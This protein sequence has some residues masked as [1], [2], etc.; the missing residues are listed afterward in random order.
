MH[1]NCRCGH[2]VVA[3]ILMVLAWVAAIGFWLA[4]WKHGK[5]VSIS[6]EHYLKEVIVFSL[7]LFGSVFCKC[8]GK[9][10]QGNMCNCE[11]GSCEGGKCGGMHGADHKHM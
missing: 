11:C 10:M 5:V 9:G 7:L 8:C 3:K 6:A 4:S 2:H 1:G